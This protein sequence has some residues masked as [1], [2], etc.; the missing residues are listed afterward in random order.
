LRTGARRAGRQL[1]DK[2]TLL[3]GRWLLD[4]DWTKSL[5]MIVVGNLFPRE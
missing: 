4:A 2:F 5:N 3:K 1:N